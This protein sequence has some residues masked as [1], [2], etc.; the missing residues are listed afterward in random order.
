MASLNGFNASEVPA[1]M[2]FSPIPNGKYRACIVESEQKANK[3]GTGSFVQLKTQI[4]DG[5]YKGRILFS[6]L[7]LD[8]PSQ[9]A[10]RIAMGELSC[11]CNAVGVLKPQDTV[12]LHNIPMDITVSCYKDKM[13]GE[14]KNKISMYEKVGTAPIAAV[15]STNPFAKK[16]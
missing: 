4:I 11:I 6:I 2:G 8:N 5:E 16:A 7:N 10:V 13:S 12:E 14:M 3:A 15:G 1:E 9:D